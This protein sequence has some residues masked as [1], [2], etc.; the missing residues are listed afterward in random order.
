MFVVDDTLLLAV[1]GEQDLP[2][3]GHLTTSAARGEV[4]TTGCWYWR[5]AGALARPGNGALSRTFR[6]MTEDERHRVGRS[7]NELPAEIGLLSLRRLIPVMAALPG[8]LN[9]L[10]AEA[11]ASAV[12]LHATIAVTT[13]SPLLTA[14]A[15]AAGVEVEVLAL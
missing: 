6:T 14:A 15:S 10:T 5:L 13:E 7:L 11:V 12:V 3:V 4:F 2:A 1:I 9:L 8:R